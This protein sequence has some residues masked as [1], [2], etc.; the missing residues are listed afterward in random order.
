MCIYVCIHMYVYLS[1]IHI[2]SPLL[3]SYIHLSYT[4]MKYNKE[5]EIQTLKNI[6]LKSPFFK[7]SPDENDTLQ[8]RG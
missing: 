1:I 8:R 6:I 4:H 2:F 7:E 5:V 3:I